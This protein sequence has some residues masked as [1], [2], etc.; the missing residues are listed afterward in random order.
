MFYVGNFI[1][2]VG[3][4]SLTYYSV[5]LRS[6]NFIPFFKSVLLWKAE[7]VKISRGHRKVLLYYVKNFDI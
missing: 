7:C 1:N 5:M 4:F 6:S 3:Y 2:L